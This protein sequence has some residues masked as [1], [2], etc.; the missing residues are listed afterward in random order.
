M[1]ESIAD[2]NRRG[3]T[4]ASAFYLLY[5]GAQAT[6]LPFL[7]LYYQGLGLSGSQ[8]GLL[9]GLSPVISLVSAPLWS[10]LADATGKHRWV[11]SFG[12]LGAA[13]GILMMRQAEQLAWLALAITCYAFFASAIIPLADSATMHMLGGEKASY[14]KIRMWGSVGWGISAPLAGKLIDGYGVK[15]GFACSASLVFLILLV[16]LGMR[17]STQRLST[18]FWHGVRQV[19]ADRRWYPFLGLAMVG[20]MCL[21]VVSS[22]LQLLMKSLGASRTQVGLSQ[23]VATLSE[24]PMLFF[25]D[26]L[27]K[28]WGARRVMGAG[29]AAYAL[30]G[31]LVSFAK[32]PEAIL[33]IQALHGTTFALMISAGV[34]LA[35]EMSPKGLKATGQG[36]W[37]A[38][39]GGVGVMSGAVLG[40][41]IFEH[42]SAAATFQVTSAIAV[43]GLLLWLTLGKGLK[44]A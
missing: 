8:I 12:L 16:S 28:R 27:I 6:F 25:V 26:R 15:A 39:M 37:S 17:H 30:R 42:Y 21:S 18:P 3:R 33:L 29:I 20:G 4:F 11:L 35:D 43:I 23:T 2:P 38:T 5:Y 36:L 32:T 31:F 41:W 22:Y 1:Q 44:E 24:I 40:G 13:G 14:G 19:L 7:T 9:A 10:G 34:T